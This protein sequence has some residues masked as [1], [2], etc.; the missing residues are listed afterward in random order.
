[1]CPSCVTNATALLPTYVVVSEVPEDPQLAQRALR[2]RL[3]V[4]D[5]LH[6]L[7]RDPGAVLQVR[8]RSAL[9]PQKDTRTATPPTTTCRPSA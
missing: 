2:E 6:L 8:G 7:D 5:L 3:G 9:T 4:E 1:L